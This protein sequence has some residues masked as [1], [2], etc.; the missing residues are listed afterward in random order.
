MRDTM[1]ISL[2]SALKKWVEQQ[3]EEGGFSTASEY[4]RDLLRQQQ[5]RAQA[6]A[7]IEHEL[8]AGLDSGPATPMTKRD[9]DDIRRAGRKRGAARN[10][11]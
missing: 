8:L 10:R 9:W 7:R 2:P 4:V 5:Q 3:V 1:H 11:R 6:R